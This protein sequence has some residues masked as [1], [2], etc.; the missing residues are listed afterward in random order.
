[1]VWTVLS[2]GVVALVLVAI[3]ALG[4]VSIAT[5]EWLEGDD[6]TADSRRVKRAD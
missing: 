4:M 1:M 5:S 2:L 3:G 6:E